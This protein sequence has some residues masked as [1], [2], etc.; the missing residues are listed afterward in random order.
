MV[1]LGDRIGWKEVP[2]LL[3]CGV[4][5]HCGVRVRGVLMGTWVVLCWL[6]L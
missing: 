1:C 4:G 3:V 5:A 6:L 2:V